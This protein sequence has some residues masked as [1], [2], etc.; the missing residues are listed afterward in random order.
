MER[1]PLSRGRF[2]LVDDADYDAVMNAGPWHAYPGTGTYYARHSISPT[3]QITLHAFLTGWCLVDHRNSDG[4]D[5]RREN[6]R[7]AT[8]M[9]NAANA[10]RRKDNSSGFKGVRQTRTGRWTAV[11]GDGTGRKRQVGTFDSDI[12]AAKA[13]DAAAR[14]R[15]GEFAR[16]NFPDEENA[17]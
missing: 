6:L 3:R 14:A 9:Q 15:W 16:L 5:N 1:V 13:Y 7:E 10:R 8:W 17:A 12:E 11:I 4:L 2:A